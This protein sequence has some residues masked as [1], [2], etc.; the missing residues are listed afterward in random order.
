MSPQPEQNCIPS[1]TTL[2]SYSGSGDQANYTIA[3]LVHFRSV[4][5]ARG[6]L[7]TDR[8]SINPRSSVEV[9]PYCCPTNIQKPLILCFFLFHSEI[10]KSRKVICR[11]TELG[12]FQKR[13]NL[14]RDK[15]QREV[16][17]CPAD[18]Q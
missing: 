14:G 9:K 1:V 5:S 10:P 4:L 3:T 18:S 16:I 17:V 13:S 7:K 2:F 11:G 6:Q 12:S 15:Y 8:R